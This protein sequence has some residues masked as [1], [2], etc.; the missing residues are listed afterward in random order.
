ME[1][2]FNA[3]INR[4]LSDRDET[5]TMSDQESKAR[6]L[7]VQFFDNAS[8]HAIRHRLIDFIHQPGNF[9]G[10][11]LDASNDT[12]E[13]DHSARSIARSAVRSARSFGS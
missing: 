1:P 12:A 13:F 9:P 3:N 10:P 4:C 2:G 7:G 11:S 5:V 8:H 6:I